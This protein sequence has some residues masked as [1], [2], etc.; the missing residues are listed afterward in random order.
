MFSSQQPCVG[1]YS[2]GVEPLPQRGVTSQFDSTAQEQVTEGVICLFAQPTQTNRCRKCFPSHA[3]N[4]KQQNIK[5]H[6]QVNMIEA[7]PRPEVTFLAILHAP[8]AGNSGFPL[9]DTSS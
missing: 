5:K 9:M 8:G 1:L 2:Q 3:H 7:A 4:V 6:T